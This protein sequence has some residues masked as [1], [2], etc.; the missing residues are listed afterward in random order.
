M[1]LIHKHGEP[2]TIGCQTSKF[3]AT[4]HSGTCYVDPNFSPRFLTSWIV[5]SFPEI[6]REIAREEWICMNLFHLWWTSPNNRRRPFSVNNVLVCSERG[7][8]THLDSIG[9]APVTLLVARWSASCVPPVKFCSW[10]VRERLRSDKRKYVEH[11]PRSIRRS[12]DYDEHCEPFVR[13]SSMA[14]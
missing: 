13:R 4:Y 11:I 10:C 8:R 9:I 14:W 2:S 1:V 5:N 6:K 12:D 7:C 3:Q